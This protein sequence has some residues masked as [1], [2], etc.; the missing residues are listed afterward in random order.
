MLIKHKKVWVHTIN[1]SNRTEDI[2]SIVAVTRE[3]AS[4]SAIT[5]VFTSES[6]RGRRCAER[7]VRH[8][9][10]TSVTFLCPHFLCSN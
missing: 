9:T 8:V 3:S 10:K 2:A 6:W 7:L 5:K 1:Q 4:V